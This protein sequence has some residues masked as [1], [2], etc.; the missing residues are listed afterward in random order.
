MS[1]KYDDIIKLPHHTSARHPRMS[2]HQRAAQFAPFAALTGHGAAISETARLTDQQ[3]EL[4][5]YERGILDM[6]VNLLLEHINEHPSVSVTYFIPDQHKAGG[7]YAILSAPVKKWDSY[8]QILTFD[9]NTKIC[10]NS[11][12]DIEGELFEK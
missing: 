8:E 5:E 11:I 6:K 9:D 1:G 7:R 3:V 2:M 12:I 4:S 10:L